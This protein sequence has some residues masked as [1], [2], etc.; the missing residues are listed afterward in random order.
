MRKA[1]IAFTGALVSCSQ[2]Q[3]SDSFGLMTQS[4]I[5][6]VRSFFMPR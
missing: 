5:L 4:A 2:T 1:A 3:F 6:I